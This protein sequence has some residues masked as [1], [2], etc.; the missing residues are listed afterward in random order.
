MNQDWK[1]CTFGH[2]FIKGN[3]D[4]ELFPCEILSKLDNRFVKIRFYILIV[5]KRK[6][7]DVIVKDTTTYWNSI[8]NWNYEK[9]WLSKGI[10]E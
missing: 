9:D 7:I 10:Q 3:G 2:D 4:H 6:L 8:D 1:K 5:E